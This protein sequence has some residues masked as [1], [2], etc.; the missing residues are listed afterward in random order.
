[1]FDFDIMMEFAIYLLIDLLDEGRPWV[2]LSAAAL[3]HLE[4]LQIHFHV[5]SY[6]LDAIFSLY[7]HFVDLNRHEVQIKILVLM[8]YHLDIRTKPTVRLYLPKIRQ[9][10]ITPARPSSA[11]VG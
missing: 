1:M 9:N 3:E 6:C 5:E 11:E 10:G 8:S 4:P 7:Y 2:F